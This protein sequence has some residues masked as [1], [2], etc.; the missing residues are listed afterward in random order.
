MGR[1]GS[2]AM[3]MVDAARG[4]HVSHGKLAHDRT[5]PRR[6]QRGHLHGHAWP[7]STQIMCMA[8]ILYCTLCGEEQPCS[9]NRYETIA[10]LV[11]RGRLHRPSLR[12]CQ[13]RASQTHYVTLRLFAIEV[14][15]SA[16]LATMIA[17]EGAAP[18]V[19]GPHVWGSLVASCFA[20]AALFRPQK[21]RLQSAHRGKQM[22]GV[23]TDV[24]NKRPTS[25]LGP[26]RLFGSELR[27]QESLLY[28]AAGALRGTKA[29][30]LGAI[31]LQGTSLR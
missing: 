5:A 25:A 20:Q 1:R 16:K 11:H 8:C 29:D 15:R 19:I 6:P 9:P 28:H 24:R 12:N 17:A 3:L 26:A 30:A 10:R 4:Q 31:S 22:R 2:L 27:A 7:S 18:C 14:A 13:S 21:K 23:P